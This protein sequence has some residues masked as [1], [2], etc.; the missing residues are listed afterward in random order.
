[1]INGAAAPRSMGT[2]DTAALQRNVAL[3]KKFRVTGTPALVFEDGKRVPGALPPVEVEK[4]LVA[5]RGKG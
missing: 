1:M 2:C 5:S 4:Q 3:G